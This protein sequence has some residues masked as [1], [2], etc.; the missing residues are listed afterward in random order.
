MEKEPGI[1]LKAA[2]MMGPGPRANLK[3]REY[4]PGQTEEYI[5]VAGKTVT[6]T[7]LEF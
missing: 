6:S 7:A 2:G 4:L 3:D 5:Q 1:A